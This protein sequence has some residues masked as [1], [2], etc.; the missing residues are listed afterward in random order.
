MI[1]CKTCGKCNEK[2]EISF[3]YKHKQYN[4]CGGYA[5]TCKI[6]TN[7]ARL[8]TRNIQKDIETSKIYWKKHI[9]RRLYS[10]CKARAKQLNLEFNIELSDIIIPSHCPYLKQKLT[11]LFAEEGATKA[12]YNPSVDRIDPTKGYVKGNIE[13]ISRRANVMKNNAT[14]EELLLFAEAIKSRL[15]QGK[16]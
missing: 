2:R 3:F 1:E 15:I 4:Y 10:S 13:I 5:P 6:C 12:W 8:N 16:Y 11:N 7:K 9:N 14:V